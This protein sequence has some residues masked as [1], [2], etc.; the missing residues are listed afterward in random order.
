MWLSVI[1]VAS[2]FRAVDVL[3]VVFNMGVDDSVYVTVGATEVVDCGLA[4]IG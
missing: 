2:C 3:L 1:S 4:P